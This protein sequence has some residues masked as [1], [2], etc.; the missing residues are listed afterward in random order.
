MA[1]ENISFLSDNF[2]VH[3]ESITIFRR[4]NGQPGYALVDAAKDKDALHIVKWMTDE[5][6]FGWP[7]DMRMAHELS[8]G[9]LS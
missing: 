3:S 5:R 2:D 9:K 6:L 8:K 1:H 4:P 7:V